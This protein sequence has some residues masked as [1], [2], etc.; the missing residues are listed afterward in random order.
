MQIL[1]SRVRGKN[2]KKKA[3]IGVSFLG[4]AALSVISTTALLA[5]EAVSRKPLI[6][7]KLFSALSSDGSGDNDFSCEYTHEKYD[8]YDAWCASHGAEEF[9]MTARDGAKLYSF[10][11]PAEAESSIYVLCAHGYRGTRYGDFG[12][13][14]Q[15]YHSL[16]YNVILIDQ[17]AQGKSEGKYIG[18][19]VF[20]SQDLIEWLNF[21]IEKFGNGIKFIIAGISMGAATVCMASGN[22]ELPENVICSVSDCAYTNAGEELKYCLPHY[23]RLPSE[24]FCTICNVLNSKTAGYSFKSADALSAVKNAKVPM[25]FIHGGADDFVPTEM[26]YELFDACPT[27][28]DLLIVE[29][30]IHAQSFFTDPEKYQ[31]K[32]KEFIDKFIN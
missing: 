2:M 14:A 17:R 6:L 23:A 8:E 30:A 3:K 27:E 7:P 13:Q 5:R 4:G 25:L 1:F 26:V 22:A 28:K 10:L 24:P 16:G 21:Y 9:E 29:N 31:E 20:E 19:G 18:F 12:A 32:V 15:F 11:I